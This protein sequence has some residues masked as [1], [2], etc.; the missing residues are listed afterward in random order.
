MTGD[1]ANGTSRQ[2]PLGYALISFRKR[3]NTSAAR[4]NS[5]FSGVCVRAR[6]SWWAFRTKG[7]EI[8]QDSLSEQKS[9]KTER[10]NRQQTLPST[11]E[12]HYSLRHAETLRK[13]PTDRENGSARHMSNQHALTA[14]SLRFS[15]SDWASATLG[16][17]SKRRVN[18]WGRWPF[19]FQTTLGISTVHLHPSFSDDVGKG[20]QIFAGSERGLEVKTSLLHLI[21]LSTYPSMHPSPPHWTAAHDSNMT[22]H[23]A[24]STSFLIHAD[25]LYR[26]CI[27]R[28]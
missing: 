22:V 7:R 6:S 11:P 17:G 21:H 23:S 25:S 15:V 12:T 9:K 4:P 2:I 1:V 19:S 28:P 26:Y 3:S 27:R 20:L 16:K 13:T 14:A 10:F 5:V 24:V 8:C 18:I